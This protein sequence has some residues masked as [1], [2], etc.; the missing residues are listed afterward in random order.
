MSK[1][2]DLGALPETDVCGWPA[3]DC[4]D[5]VYSYS[6]EAMEAERRRCYELGRAAA[7]AAVPDC[8]RVV[9]CLSSGLVSTG[10]VHTQ[11]F[12]I[13][14]D[15]WRVQLNGKVLPHTWNSKGAALAGLEVELRRAYRPGQRWRA[16]GGV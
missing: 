3:R 12:C 16:V 1:P 14:E 10:K 2:A 7:S 9:A 4:P 5:E 8:H 6:A 11:V 13:V 15:E